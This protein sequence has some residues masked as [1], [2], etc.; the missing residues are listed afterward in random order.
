M[1]TSP[2][3]KRSLQGRRIVITGASSGIGRALAQ[4]LAP[5]GTRLI[6]ASR[7]HDKLKEVA[8][9]LPTHK[10]NVRIVSTDVTSES[11]RQ[12]LLDEAV[13]QFGGL[14]VLI[15]NAGIASW[16]HFADGTEEILRQIM[17]V[18]FFAPA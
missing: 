11:D 14:D 2:A 4:Q 16:A 1:R 7:S 15:N 12:H 6:L 8:D 10:D 9:S 13:H 17:E 18:N 5:L 3:M